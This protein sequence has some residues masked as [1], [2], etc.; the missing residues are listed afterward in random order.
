MTIISDLTYVF[1]T[2]NSSVN[3]IIYYFLGESFRKELKKMAEESR[4]E[5]QKYLSKVF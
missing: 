2:I 4:E 5:L 3:F 1:V